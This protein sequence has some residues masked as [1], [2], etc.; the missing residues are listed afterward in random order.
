MN[1]RAASLAAF[2]ILVSA[3][4]TLVFRHSLFATHP[5][6]IAVQALAVLLMIWARVTLKWRSFQPMATPTEGDLVTTGPYRF[7][8]HPIYAA[9]FYFLIAG[10]VF[11]FALVNILVILV[12]IIAIAVRLGS[13]ERLLTGQYPQY[14][15]YAART[16]RV[17][18]F[19]L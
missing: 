12:A 9:I 6:G 8:R 13:E 17:I 19:V 1:H 15:A 11:H 4:A 18:P 10:L 7:I 2:V 14:T 5:A 3:I 16:K